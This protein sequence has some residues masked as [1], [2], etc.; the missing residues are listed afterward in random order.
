MINKEINDKVELKRVSQSQ[1]GMFINLI[2]KDVPAEDILDMVH[3]AKLVSEGFNVDCK[4]SDIE[5]FYELDNW[6]E[7][8]EIESK[9]IEYGL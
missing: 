5:T 7:N 8:F 4:A 2:H 6:Q 1:L 9:I 3:L